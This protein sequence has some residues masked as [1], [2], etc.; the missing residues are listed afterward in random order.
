MDTAAKSEPDALNDTE[1]TPTPSL[2]ALSSEDLEQFRQW[3]AQQSAAKKAPE[4]S[5]QKKARLQEDEEIRTFID[6][7]TDLDINFA[8]LDPTLQDKL[9][10]SAT[11]RTDFLA[12]HNATEKYDPTTGDFKQA[13]TKKRIF[14]PG[15]EQDVPL[16]EVTDNTSLQQAMMKYHKQSMLP[17]M[18]KLYQCC[19]LFYNQVQAE[20]SMQQITTER[21]SAQLQVLER[22]RANKTVLLLDLPALFN[23]KTLDSNLYHYVN[24]AGLQWT[25]IAALHNHMVTS[26]SSVAR[27][28][29]VTEMQ[30]Q[31]FRDY[32]RQ[33][34]RYW[35]SPDIPDCKIRIEQ[36][37][38]T[39]D[40]LAMQPFYA[41]ID[42]L[43]E[44]TDTPDLQTWRQTLQ[45]WTPRDEEPKQLL[46]QV[47]YVLDPR[48]PRRYT[49]LLLVHEKYYDEF[50][51]KWHSKFTK[52]LHDTV[53]LI[54]A[55]R[56]ATIDRTT[57]H[58]ASFDKAFD[59]TTLASLQAFTYPVMPVR[60]S[61]ELASLL[62]SHPMLP[63]QGA[64]GLTA[65]TAQAFQDHGVAEDFTKG[66]P[67]SRP[68]GKGKQTQTAWGRFTQNYSTSYSYSSYPAKGSKK[69]HGKSQAKGDWKE[70]DHDHR[71]NWKDPNNDTDNNGDR[72][73]SGP[74][75]R[76]APQSQPLYG[77]ARST[78]NKGAKQQT[79][80]SCQEGKKGY[81]QLQ[82]V[83]IC[84]TCSCALGF[85]IDCQECGRHPVPPGFQWKD[86]APLRTLICPCLNEAGV[87]CA[88]PLG[89]SP[90]CEFCREHR[91]YW[92][93]QQVRDNWSSDPTPRKAELLMMDR[94]LYELDTIQEATPE[95]TQLLQAMKSKIEGVWREQFSPS[96]YAAHWVVVMY[97]GD[98][99][100][101]IPLPRPTKPAWVN[102]TWD[103]EDRI[104]NMYGPLADDI[105]LATFHL[106][107]WFNQYFKHVWKS[108]G[109][110]LTKKYRL[111]SWA[112]DFDVAHCQLIPWDR[113]LASSF[114]L[115]YDQACN[116]QPNPPP[117]QWSRDLLV[118]FLDSAWAR[119]TTDLFQT[120]AEEFV[121]FLD[122]DQT[123]KACVLGQ[124]PFNNAGV[125]T[126]AGFG[127]LFFDGVFWQVAAIYGVL[128]DST[129]SQLQAPNDQLV[130]LL[131]YIL[132]LLQ[133]SQND[134]QY[135][136]SRA[137]TNKGN[138]ME[139]LM[140]A[141]AEGGAHWLAWKTAWTVFQHQHR[142][143]KYDWV[144][145]VAVC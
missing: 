126:S 10:S 55:L 14:S 95:T 12:I 136:K 84:S 77:D 128:K 115:A 5:P 119:T 89:H 27:V 52:R 129:K 104:Y 18:D 86:T 133:L 108:H 112:L 53:Q 33:T 94:L 24:G 72:W 4:L 116:E 144:A 127:S 26:H 130:L 124:P 42:L 143:S 13:A 8:D 49:C 139:T 91:K 62:E 60:I 1:P 6:K 11:A 37:L 25:D 83:V 44:C 57:T 100:H 30:A 22:A 31:Q 131:E 35:K 68:S 70:R 111:P 106:A 48:Y 20:F 29:F 135:V 19:D 66:S 120:L 140:L 69:G 78:A 17:N 114:H 105:L 88:Q 73:G 75:N 118:W 90:A 98:L 61:S 97:E 142:N 46:A 134:I 56:R 101:L 103:M 21:H 39:D 50:L 113:L 79:K 92:S 28:E 107:S 36:D 132:P 76:F 40:R 82:Q 145:Q 2:P 99:G 137:H 63:F 32:M 9:K 16:P 87:I 67:K 138:I 85:N 123:L 38:P 141:L 65:L 43:A 122:Y 102:P 51:V 23:K 117:L 54:Q 110:R 125:A 121:W 96:Q 81:S 59:L 64:G 15:N 41:L 7:L 47:A 34:R 80:N 74:Y 45:I 93:S 3:Q 109:P 71:T 58:R